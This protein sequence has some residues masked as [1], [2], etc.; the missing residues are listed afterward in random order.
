MVKN[1]VRFCPKFFVLYASIYGTLLHP[2]DM[3]CLNYSVDK[4]NPSFL[5][6]FG[7]NNHLDKK[8]EIYIDS[9]HSVDHIDCSLVTPVNRQRQ[10][11]GCQ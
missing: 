6:F 4:S 5:T 3:V 1:S 9:C 11:D 2:K 10:S 7:K 8:H